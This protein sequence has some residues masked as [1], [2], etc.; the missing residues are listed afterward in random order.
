MHPRLILL[1]AL[2]TTLAGHSQPVPDSALIQQVK[3]AYSLSS[4][5]P[6][7][8]LLIVKM[9]LERAKQ[10][11]NDRLAAYAYKAKGWALFHKGNFDSCYTNM[12]TATRLFQQ[13]QDTLE[14]MFMYTHLALAYSNHSRFAESAAYLMKA[15]SLAKKGKN[16]KIEAAVNRQMGI[17]YR[18]Q[19]D[20]NK[21]VAYLKAGLALYTQLKDTLGISDAISSLA[22]AYTHYLDKPDSSLALL[23]TADTL[24][25]VKKGFTYQKAT[26]NEQWGDAYFARTDYD[27]ALDHYK[28]A[29]NIFASQ[30]EKADMYYEAI[31]VGKTYGE[32]KNYAEGEKYLLQAYKGNDSL[33][34]TNYSYDAA[35]ELAKLY[36]EKGDWQKAFHWM[37]IRFALYDSVQAS[38]QKS[39]TAELQ[40]KYETQ[41]KDAEISLLKKDQDVDRLTIQNQKTFRYGAV[42]LLVLLALI[43]FLFINRYR[44]VQNAKRQVEMERLRNHIARDLHDDMGSSLS[45]INI[46]SKVALE[47]PDEQD[48]IREYLKKIRDNSGYMME[49]MSDIVWAINPANDNFESVLFKMKEFAADMLEPLNI[50]YEFIQTG[51]PSAIEMGLDKR[52]DLYLIFKE[53]INNIAKYSYCKKVAIT[54]TL[55]KDE[56]GLRVEDDGRG[57]DAAAAA[58][59]AATGNGLRN[60]R[61]RA[62]KMMGNA[63]ITSEKGK[64][65]TVLLKLKPQV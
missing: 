27:K 65:T 21:A 34:L 10:T 54:I 22:I 42:A 8:A 60:M 50:Q 20:F 26:I 37:E 12:L 7:S 24:L 39:K 53:A 49:S 48:N 52:K 17:L 40:T 62:E 29:Y 31:G 56:I 16:L 32:L 55:D 33:K 41:K 57:F 61:Q 45:S 46:I 11:N 47:K 4:A 6:D 51:D 35:R 14:T 63:T 64:G 28:T 43:G 13:L 18:Q 5:N 59:N 25:N 23:K 9:G 15:D 3:A 2:S 36:Q 30:D 1:I 44:I 38:E 19:G 58:T